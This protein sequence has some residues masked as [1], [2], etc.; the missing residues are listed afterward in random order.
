MYKILKTEKLFEHKRITILEDDIEYE[1]GELSKF[2]KFEHKANAAQVIGIRDDG[3]I[4]LI[5]EYSHTVGERLLG[6]PG[7]LIGLEEDKFEGGKR[8]F[9]E[10]TGYS[11]GKLEYLGMT[12]PYHRRLPEKLFLFVARELTELGEQRED[13]EQDMEVVWMTEAEVG[14]AIKKNEITNAQTLAHWAI[15]KS[16]LAKSD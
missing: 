4:C 15:Y 1:N 3:K 9:L 11:A 7:G 16:Q 5:R 10:E 14:Q 2:L 6:F 12:Y 8:E 13:S